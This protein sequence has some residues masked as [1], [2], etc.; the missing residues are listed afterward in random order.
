MADIVNLSSLER[1][2]RSL[3]EGMPEGGAVILFFTGVQYVRDRTA[4]LPCAA[5]EQ[6]ARRA[7]GAG[8]SS[9][10]AR[11]GRRTLTRQDS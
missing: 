10:R 8:D 4:Y 1:P 6:P 7:A 2:P 9:S 11:R 3:R 5:G